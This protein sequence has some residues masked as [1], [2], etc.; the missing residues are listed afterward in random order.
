MNSCRGVVLVTFIGTGSVHHL[1]CVDSDAKIIYDSMEWRPMRLSRAALQ[2]C[3]GDGSAI[4]RLFVR[5][6][7]SQS[8]PNK[9]GTPLGF[10]NRK[11]RRRKDRDEKHKRR[12]MSSE[13]SRT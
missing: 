10:S 6:V 11:K 4:R 12:R 2:F 1:V 8:V 3:A 5:K 13:K 9:V 7:V